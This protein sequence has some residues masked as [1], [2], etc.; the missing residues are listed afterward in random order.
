MPEIVNLEDPATGPFEAGKRLAFNTIAAVLCVFVVTAVN[1]NLFDRQPNLALFGM[2][3]LILVMLNHPMFKRW[4]QT[5][6]VRAIDLL[7]IMAT[8]ISFGFVFFQ[9]EPKLATFWIDGTVLGDRAG[10]ETH[11]DYS[12]ALVGLLLVLETTRRAIGW[13]LPIL[14]MIFI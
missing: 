8:V 1:F 7:L 4:G 13:T 11:L 2:M 5:G 12:I 6:F 3:G 14:C 10:N 9:S